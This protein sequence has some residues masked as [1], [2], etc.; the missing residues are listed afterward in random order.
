MCRELVAVLIVV[1][2]VFGDDGAVSHGRFMRRDESSTQFWVEEAQAT[3]R[4]RH[5]HGAQRTTG[6]ARNV[7]LF[8]ADGMSMSTQTAARILLGQRQGQS[9]EEHKLSFDEFPTSGFAKTYCLNWQVPD[10]ACTATACLCGVKANMGTVGVNGAVQRHNCTASMDP[11]RQVDSIAQWALADGRDA[12][13]VTTTRVTDATP[14]AAFANAGNRNWENDERIVAAGFDPATC[15]DITQQLVHGNPGSQFKV[16]LGGGRRNFLPNTVNDEEGTPG[17]RTDGRNL[18]EEW[19]AAK[20]AQNVT[21]K[22]IWNREEL[23]ELASSPPDYLLGLFEGNH[24]QYHLE[25]DN[26]TEPTL[27]EM[28]EVAIRSLSRNERGF[29]L[30]V[31]G[32]RIDHAHHD[33]HPHLALDET[34]EL[35][36]AVTRAM[37]MLDEKDSL[38][39]VTSDH[40]H[41]M[42]I[43]GYSSRG[44]DIL[45]PT[46][47][48]DDN[49][50]PFMTLSY[51]NGPGG[52][53]RPHTNGVRV[54]VTQDPD[55]GE[56]RW[57]AH[58]DVPLWEDTH[59]GE[60]VGVFA[61]GPHHEM[62]SGL[63]EQSHIPHRMAYAAC[64]GPGLHAC[65]AAHSLRG[66]LL[67]ALPLL[68][69]LM[70]VIRQ[71][72]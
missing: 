41:V 20:A 12:G 2:G 25:A 56:L 10:S 35:H 36:K 54:D 68:A 9:G 31:E 28:T 59:A 19:Q 46:D 63:Y 14:A 66:S 57:R 44:K 4:Q 15:P 61:R 64:I 48:G 17:N 58:V 7:V 1:C 50:V 53:G 39:V 32:G 47:H 42:T 26:T 21:Y 16:I 34:I 45:G 67:A 30:F 5:T 22:Y 71:D 23:N 49:G 3:L 37:E 18:I 11:A 62:F 43:N 29:F 65:S 13:I 38:L 24:M 72:S 8:L 70:A 27:A 69:V 60:D 40:S 51:T 55:F 6:H 52:R 33:N